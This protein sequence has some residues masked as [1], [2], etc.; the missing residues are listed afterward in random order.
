MSNSKIKEVYRVSLTADEIITLISTVDSMGIM[1]PSQYLFQAM[2]KLKLQAAKIHAG[3]ANA[4]YVNTGRMESVPLI[5]RLGIGSVSDTSIRKATDA[6]RF[7]HTPQEQIDAEFAAMDHKIQTGE[8]KHWSEF[9]PLITDVSNN[10]HTGEAPNSTSVPST[11]T[12]S[13]T[14]SH[15][16]EDSYHEI[17]FSKL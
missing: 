12:S 7:S 11:I 17:D 16:K 4:A 10:I 13:S 5:N 9:L 1:N 2:K 6:E 15:N 14:D 3:V 8:D